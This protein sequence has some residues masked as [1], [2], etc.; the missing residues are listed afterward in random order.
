MGGELEGVVRHCLRTFLDAHNSHTYKLFTVWVVRK[1]FVEVSKTAEA[2]G[3]G[4]FRD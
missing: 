4:R 1:Y 3:Q 2:E